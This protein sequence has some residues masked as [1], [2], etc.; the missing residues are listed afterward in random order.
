MTDPLRLLALQTNEQ[1]AWRAVVA[2][3]RA[4]GAGA[5]EQGEPNDRLHD[6]VVRWGEELAQLRLNDPNENHAK[7]ALQQ[8]RAAYHRWSVIDKR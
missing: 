3:L 5:I 6:A 7:D 1:E 8:R 4:A 2:E